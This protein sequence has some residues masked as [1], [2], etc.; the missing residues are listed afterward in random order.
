MP[1]IEPG[2]PI[3]SRMPN[4]IER[5]RSLPTG[6]RQRALIWGLVF[7]AGAAMHLGDLVTD[8]TD[9]YGWAPRPVE[10]FFLALVVLDA[11]V[12][13]LIGLLQRAGVVLGLV[14]ILAEVVVSWW[15][16]SY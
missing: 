14:T 6:L 15:A 5:L 8:G 2:E 13:V 10:I 4:R 3:G 12:I 11:A 1:P 16:L 9:V 7:A